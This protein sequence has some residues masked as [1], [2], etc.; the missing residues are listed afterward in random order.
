MHYSRSINKCC[1]FKKIIK[2]Y[3][4]SKFASYNSITK[5]FGHV[6][7][8]SQIVRHSDS[9]ACSLEILIVCHVAYVKI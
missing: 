9:Y 4:L 3:Q 1:D 7:V 2:V 6:V 8:T 5:Q